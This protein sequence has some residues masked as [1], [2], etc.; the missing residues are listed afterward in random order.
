MA[1]VDPP[2]DMNIQYCVDPNTTIGVG[3]GG[4]YTSTNTWEWNDI[5]EDRPTVKHL[6]RKLDELTVLLSQLTT[7]NRSILETV[8]L[9]LEILKEHIDDPAAILLHRQLIAMV[10]QGLDKLPS[11]DAIAALLADQVLHKDVSPNVYLRATTPN[12]TL[13]TGDKLEFTLSSHTQ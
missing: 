7:V 13:T 5:N 6:N 11:Q 2:E 12:V 4:Y 10:E 1:I 3:G 8:V 9:G